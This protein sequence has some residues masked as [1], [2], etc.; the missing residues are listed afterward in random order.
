MEER[1][2]RVEVECKANH[3]RKSRRVAFPLD[4]AY[5]IKPL[6]ILWCMLFK[7]KI[8]YTDNSIYLISKKGLYI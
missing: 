6:N 3:L 8:M 5:W 1:V 4:S 2:E 7:G